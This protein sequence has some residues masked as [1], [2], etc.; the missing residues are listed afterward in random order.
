MFIKLNFVLLA[1]SFTVVVQSVRRVCFFAT[2]WTAA[3]RAPLFPTTSWG[4][5]KFI[6]IELVTLLNHL[7]FCHPLLLLPSI[8]PSIRVFSSESV[9]SIKWPK[10]CS[11]SF[12]V[13]PSNQYSGLIS[14][15][16]EWFKLCPS[17]PYLQIGLHIIYRFPSK[18]QLRPDVSWLDV[19][20]LCLRIGCKNHWLISFLS[21]S[22]LGLPWCLNNKESACNVE[23]PDLIL[24]SGRFPGEKN[25]NA[26]QYSC[27][28]YPRGRGAWRA[29]VHRIAELDMTE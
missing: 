5:L 2:S 23:G 18:T 7:I 6:S 27:L 11:F 15:R 4:L 13:S 1:S 28:G 12:S 26:L 25:G 8:F 14:F 21:R 9:L 19:N 10:Y 20:T 16:I 17:F 29:T 3:R 22:P 24:G